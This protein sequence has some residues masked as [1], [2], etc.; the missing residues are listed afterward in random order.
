MKRLKAIKIMALMGVVACG[1]LLYAC[2]SFTGASIPP[3]LKTFSVQFFENRAA[4]VDPTLSQA[5]TEGLKDRISRQSPLQ[6]NRVMGDINFEGSI[7]T[8]KIEPVALTT[9][10]GGQAE[11]EQN[12]LTI[13]V[14]V[15]CT[16]LKDEKLSFE[17]SFSQFKNFPREANFSSVQQEL[18]DEIISD[19]T[20]AIFN[21]AFSNW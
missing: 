11:A 1:F 4:L 19:L 15:K 10:K 16:N 18:N 17:Q 20:L 8:Y 14:S 13:A 7:I 6:Y 3:S 5:F 9:T 21:R 2:Y 12:R